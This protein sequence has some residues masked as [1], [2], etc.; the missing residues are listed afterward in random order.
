MFILFCI[1]Y[2]LGFEYIQETGNLWGDFDQD[3]CYLYFGVIQ[4]FV[5]V[6]SNN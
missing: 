6:N 1:W 3:P 5:E 2:I 4:I